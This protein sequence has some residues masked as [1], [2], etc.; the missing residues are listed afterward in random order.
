M[1]ANFGWLHSSHSPR[2]ITAAVPTD[3]QTS[4]ATD[5]LCVARKGY[6]GRVMYRGKPTKNKDPVGVGG[7]AFA[8]ARM[9][10][11]TVAV[12][13]MAYLEVGCFFF[14]CGAVTELVKAHSSMDT[15]EHGLSPRTTGSLQWQIECVANNYMRMRELNKLRDGEGEKLY[16][17]PVRCCA[18]H[19]D[20][21]GRTKTR[22]ANLSGSLPSGTG[23]TD[24]LGH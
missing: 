1:V 4:T 24:S 9:G 15:F 18:P 10:H 3:Q 12:V 23:V 5:P 22:L 11:G 6:F 20:G 17:Q 13:C 8:L 2:D 7:V 14:G 21:T 19:P 16:T